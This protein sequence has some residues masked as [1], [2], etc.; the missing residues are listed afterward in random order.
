MPIQSEGS[1]KSNCLLP[2]FDDFLELALALEDVPMDKPTAGKGSGGV[3]DSLSDM[4]AVATF[5]DN[6]AHHLRLF[7]E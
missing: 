5:G 3:Q 7:T 4:T 2:M 6:A 1:W